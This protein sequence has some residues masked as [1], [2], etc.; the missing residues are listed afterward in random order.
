MQREVGSDKRYIHRLV[1]YT[2]N[3]RLA[4]RVSLLHRDYLDNKIALALLDEGVQAIFER[5]I[6]TNEVNTQATSILTLKEKVQDLR[7]IIS[8]STL[9]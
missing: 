5:L 7:Y 9:R 2:R 3:C 6:S 8:L 1:C 4:I